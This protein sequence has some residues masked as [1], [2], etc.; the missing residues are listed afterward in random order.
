MYQGVNKR[1]ESSEEEAT[2]TELEAVRDGSTLRVE[3][4]V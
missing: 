1:M 3:V 2:V 4:K